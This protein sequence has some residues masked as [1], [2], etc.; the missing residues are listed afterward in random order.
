MDEIN[1]NKPSR[2]YFDDN[3]LAALG[4]YLKSKEQGNNLTKF[5]TDKKFTIKDTDSTYRVINHWSSLGLFDDSRT[6]N[7][8]WRKFSLVDIV[9]LKVLMEIRKFGLSLEKLKISYESI[10]S[11]TAIFEYSILSCLMR[12]AMYVIVFSDGHIEIT[13]KYA[14]IFSEANSYLNEASHLTINLNYCLE[15][16]FPG[17]DLSAQLNTFELS[18]K[19]SRI[20]EELRLKQSEEVTVKMKND[21]PDLLI[22]KTRYKKDTDTEKNLKVSYGNVTTHVEDNHVMYFEKTEK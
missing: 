8:G 9:W 6:E 19:E 14:V 22:T 4:Q 7:K 10:K 13:P 15:R 17:K 21:S 1:L 18:K 20:L 11:K 3:F 2:I 16:I 5:L 12:N